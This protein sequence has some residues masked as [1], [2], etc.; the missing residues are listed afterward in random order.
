MKDSY[1]ENAMLGD[2]LVYVGIVLIISA[3][4]ASI[5]SFFTLRKQSKQLNEEL[6]ADYGKRQ[7]D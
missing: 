2:T 4:I 6:E 1:W 7:S 5:I 3:T